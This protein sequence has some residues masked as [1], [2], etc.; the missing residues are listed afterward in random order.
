M[1]RPADGDGF[2]LAD[3]CIIYARS[4]AAA[5]PPALET[6]LKTDWSVW[7]DRHLVEGDYRGGIEAAIRAC[8][9]LI[10]VWSKAAT[11]NAHMHD[12]LEIARKTGVAIL[13]LRIDEASAPMSY[14]SLQ[15]T[16]MLGWGGDLDRVEL[17]DFQGRIRTVIEARRPDHRPKRLI[18][19]APVDL[20][21][22]FYSVSS[23]ETRLAPAAALRTLNMFGVE[24]ILASAYDTGPGAPK[25][26]IT[27]LERRRKR[28]ATILLDSGNYEKARRDDK[29]WTFETF[30][31]ALQ[32]TPHDLAF[33]YDTL[34]PKGDV[35]KVANTAIE[36]ARRTA[37][38][39]PAPV[40][41]IVHLPRQRDGDYRTDMAGSVMRKVAQALAPV[42]IAIPE[43]E[44]GSGVFD[45][46]RTMAAIRAALKGLGRYQAVHILGAGNPISLALLSAAGAD[47]FDGLEWCRYA[48]DA[49]HAQLHHFQLF[50]LFRYQAEVAESLVAS[51]AAVDPAVSYTTKA[52]MHNLDF[53]QT[54]LRGLRDALRDEKTLVAFL[55]ELLPKGAMTQARAALPGV[56]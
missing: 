4:D 18:M 12:E 1:P 28:G 37:R 56:L 40:I 21:A 35:D 19:N 24:T 45:R 31:M 25:S 36:A 23:H 15:S 47:S 9:V 50:E 22:F 10:P 29:S 17:A 32:A 11:L 39:T 54:W 5:I 42:M 13:P 33:A 48:F 43:R 44:L 7:W 26:L 16:D 34:D 6:V 53:Y 38:L 20:P 2:D 14:G 55:A 49:E 3:I 51:S 46:A 30:K 27:T 41:P 52:V 8:E